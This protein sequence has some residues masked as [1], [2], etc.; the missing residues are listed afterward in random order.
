MK[1]AQLG[2][3]DLVVSRIC[4]GCWQLSPKFWGEIP[5]KPW[6]KALDKAIELG[7]NFID[8]AGAY[9]D[10]YAESCLGEYFA[11]S[12]N[13]DHFLVATK[14]YWTFQKAE[15]HPDTSYA[16]ILQ[17]CEDALR[18]MKTDRIDLFQVHMWDPLTRPEEVA[19]AFVEL[20]RQGKVRWFGVSNLNTEQISLYLKHI[21]VV[22]L[23]PWYN[24]LER[25][26]EKREFPFCL[27][28]RIGVI[29][30]SPLYR[31]LLTGKYARNHQFTDDRANLA[32]YQGAAFQRMLDG[33]DALRP[34]AESL[35]LTVAQFAIRWI[36]TN[37]TVT[38]AIVGIKSPEHVE[39][40]APA[41]ETMLS[42]EDWYKA[43]QIIACAKQ[44]ALSLK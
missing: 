24:L 21:P 26:N 15:R 23:Q 31:G 27:E 37:P 29:P 30:Y 38:S 44:E 8:T 36:L 34:I 4:F 11:A 9:G 25:D 22:S 32:L 16:F 6:K 39:S 35:G 33:I 13:R 10:G 14:F 7:I 18:R 42:A 20:R 3:S 1:Y 5:L 43:A 41:A 2:T 19:A 28:H 12:R 40:I 17:E